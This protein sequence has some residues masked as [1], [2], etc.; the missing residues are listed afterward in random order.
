MDG[1]ASIGVEAAPIKIA[2]DSRAGRRRELVET[3][4]L[5][6]FIRMVDAGSLTRAAEIL[7]IA[8]PA[9]S[10][11]V[12]ALEADFGAPLLIRSRHGVSPTA[13]GRSLYRQA[14][15]ILKQLE[16]AHSEVSQLADE[17]SGLVHIGLSL[18]AALALSV[19]LVRDANLS[20]PNVSLE[21]VDGLPSNLLHELTL[22]G[23][24]DISLFPGCVS[25]RG[26]TAEPLVAER[27][28]LIASDKTPLGA[29][30]TPISVRE[31]EGHPLV[32][33]E[34]SNRVRQAVESGFALVGLRP[35]VVVEMNSIYGLCAAVAADIGSAIVP[36]AGA[37]LAKPGL[38]I[39][40]IVDPTIERSLYLAVS[41]APLSP[42]A[43]AIR[44]LIVGTTENVIAS[45]EWPGARFAREELDL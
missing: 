6:A 21:L 7:G 26:I 39:R 14:Q 35:K 28:V 11:Q 45:G 16:Q 1:I 31:L 2:Y 30:D 12:A 43:Q 41:D 29:S 3:R 8:Q 32:L 24:F 15:I 27:L 9:L 33:P 38:K 19:P 36:L 17:V 37:R 42:A 44:S 20:L 5:S 34:A 25:G 13:A 10:Q 18:T 23:R 22:N 40:P 4:R